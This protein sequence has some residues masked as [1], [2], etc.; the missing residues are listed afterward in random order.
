GPD[1]NGESSAPGFKNKIE[2]L[3]FHHDPRD[4]RNM[5]VTKYFDTVS[6][7]LHRAAMEGKVFSQVDLIIGRNDAERVSVVLRYKLKN[8]RISSVTLGGTEPGA[9]LETLT[10]DYNSI[11]WDYS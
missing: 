5:A 1:I 9:L 2:L 8:V 10:L 4:S 11:T 6:P 3:S 7:L